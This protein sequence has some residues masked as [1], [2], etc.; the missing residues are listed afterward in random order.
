LPDHVVAANLPASATAL[1]RRHVAGASSIITHT[2][3]SFE[4]A[5]SW[6]QIDWL[7]DRTSLP[8]VLKGV[9]HPLDAARAAE[10][11]VA[12]LVVSNHG[13]RQLDSAIASMT[14]LPA[15]RDA[16]AGR[17]ELLLDGGVR[18]GTDV[19]KA[20]ATGAGGVLLGRS[21]LWGLAMGGYA[22][23]RRVFTLL[24]EEI[25]DTMALGGC[26]DVAAAG[27]L[28]TTSAGPC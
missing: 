1:A 22:G 13:G 12:G 11:G 10:M 26:P 27:A 15:V 20:L 28:S 16:V 14:A 4:P 23:A 17:C 19:V 8:I 18:S 25:E 9:L 21:V 2:S 5:L 6:S 24:H 7:R 3:S